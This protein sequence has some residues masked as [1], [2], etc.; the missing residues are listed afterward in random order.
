MTY[1]DEP[2]MK[3]ADSL[4]KR[5][6]IFKNYNYYLIPED[7]SSIKQEFIAYFEKK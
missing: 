6:D 3:G 2:V 4:R 1:R 5:Q 7:T